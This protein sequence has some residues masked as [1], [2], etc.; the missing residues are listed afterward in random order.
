[1]THRGMVG[2]SVAL[3]LVATAG[4]GT[5]L[6]LDITPCGTNENAYS[7]YGGVCHDLGMAVNTGREVVAGDTASLVVLPLGVAFLAIDLPLCVVGDTVTLPLVLAHW[8]GAG[9]KHID[10]SN[11]RQYPP[12][13]IVQTNEGLEGKDPESSAEPGRAA[14]VSPVPYPRGPRPR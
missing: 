7:P 5:L 9:R 2:V 11:L 13:P 1:V 8:I 4:C 6:N 12:R 3:L 10:P 14:E